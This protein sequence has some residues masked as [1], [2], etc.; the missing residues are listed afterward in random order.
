MYSDTFHPSN[1]NNQ[2]F[3]LIDKADKNTNRAYMLFGID[4]ID[5]VKEYFPDKDIIEVSSVDTAAFIIGIGHIS[6][7]SITPKNAVKHYHIIQDF[8]PE[9]STEKAY[10]LINKS[11]TNIH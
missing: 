10:V 3:A 11:S 7:V 6:T 9:I 8:P 5:K 2:M 1:R 4:M